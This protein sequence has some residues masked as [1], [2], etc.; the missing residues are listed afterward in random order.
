MIS[1]NPQ[2][3]DFLLHIAEASP[4]PRTPHRLVTPIVIAT[5][6]PLVQVVP[7]DLRFRSTASPFHLLYRRSFGIRRLRETLVEYAQWHSDKY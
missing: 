4:W 1:L 5:L 7:G 3:A 2:T 6:L